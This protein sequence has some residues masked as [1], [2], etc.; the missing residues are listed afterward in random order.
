MPENPDFVPMD[1]PD[2]ANRFEDWLEEQAEN[3]TISLYDLNWIDLMIYVRLRQVATP[4]MMHMRA[5]A[6]IEFGERLLHT[7]GAMV[8]PETGDELVP[9]LVENAADQEAHFDMLSISGQE[10]DDQAI[11]D[12]IASELLRSD[13]EEE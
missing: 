13:G 6:L 10:V 2:M 11:E 7:P 12:L 8:D 1:E 3:G 5:H 4:Q 9:I